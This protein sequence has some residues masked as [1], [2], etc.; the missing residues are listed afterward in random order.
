MTHPMTSIA[1]QLNAAQLAISNSQAD[2]EI[3]ALVSGFGYSDKGLE[4]GCVNA[5]YSIRCSFSWHSR[6]P[7]F[8]EQFFFL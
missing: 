8:L 7:A 6:C 5:K 4:A 2:E 1:D 3:Q